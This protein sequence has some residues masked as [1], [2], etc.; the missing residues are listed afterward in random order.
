MEALAIFARPLPYLNNVTNDV[1]AAATS[2]TDSDLTDVIVTDADPGVPDDPA[3]AADPDVEATSSDVFIPALTHVQQ[4]RLDTRVQSLMIH[5]TDLFAENEA[6]DPF[7]SAWQ[8]LTDSV[9]AVDRTALNLLRAPRDLSQTLDNDDTTWERSTFSTGSGTRSA[10]K[11]LDPCRAS[12]QCMSFSTCRHRQPK[13]VLQ[14]LQ[15]QW[16]NQHVGVGWKILAI[17]AW[18]FQIHEFLMLESCS[19]A[20]T[21]FG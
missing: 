15:L 17:S 7:Q 9:A 4:Q 18:V 16:Q 6:D 2:D 11:V 5:L 19:K 21:D 8:A 3:P 20:Q 10:F 13:R 14:D 1:P 12:N